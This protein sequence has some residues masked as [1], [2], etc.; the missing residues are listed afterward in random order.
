MESDAATA[1]KDRPS[2]DGSSRTM[3][4]P[5]IDHSPRLSTLLD[6]RRIVGICSDLLGKDF[7]YASGDGN[8]YS[9]DTGWQCVDVPRPC[10]LS[11]RLWQ[12]GAGCLAR[13]IDVCALLCAA[14]TAATRTSD[15]L[16]SRSLST[17]IPWIN[18][19]AVS[20]CSPVATRTAHRGE[21]IRPCS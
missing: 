4:V 13:V 5:T 3:I 12:R 1:G 16:P 14:L 6:D 17:W 10:L 7:C 11:L 2:H 21:Q 18:I 19:P 9:G 20:V 8:Y 15:A